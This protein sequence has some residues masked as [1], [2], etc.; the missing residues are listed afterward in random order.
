VVLAAF[1]ASFSAA[2]ASH[3]PGGLGVFELLFVAIMP[4]VPKADVLAA[5]IVFRL[6]YLIIPFAIAI[7][8]VL[9]FERARLAQSWRDRTAAHGL[10]P[11][12]SPLHMPTTTPPNPVAQTA[13]VPVKAPPP[14]VG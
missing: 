4:D 10:S 3:A 7:V 1:L 14:G 11:I 8:V 5:L 13:A 6:F 2:L 9:L 12:P